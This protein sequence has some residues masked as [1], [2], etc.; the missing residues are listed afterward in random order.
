MEEKGE[1]RVGATLVVAGFLKNSRGEVLLVDRDGDW[2]LPTGHMN[3]MIDATLQDALRREMKEE[4]GLKDLAKIRALDTFVR[5]TELVREGKRPLRPKSIA[6]Y[7]CSVVNS[8]E[9]GYLGE[10]GRRYLK[11][12]DERREVM[13]IRP[14]QAWALPLDGLTKFSL[15]AEALLKYP[16][17][18]RRN[19]Y[20]ESENF[21]GNPGKGAFEESQV[22]V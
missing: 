14:S 11:E 4:L 5:K 16:R 20:D 18:E 12:G 22:V 9:I 15:E 1:E 19:G 17:R 7:S 10:D 21:N 6:V 3:V 2:T 8:G 13:C